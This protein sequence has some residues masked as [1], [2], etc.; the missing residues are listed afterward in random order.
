MKKADRRKCSNLLIA[1]HPRSVLP[2]LAEAIGL[3]EAIFVQQLHWWLIREDSKSVHIIDGRRWVYNSYGEW[4]KSNFQFWSVSTIKRTVYEAERTG[5]VVSDNFNRNPI[6]K[7][8]W[9]TLDYE[10]VEALEN[11]LE[12]GDTST[13]QID[14]M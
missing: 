4:Q 7:T 14:T 12:D 5:L 3:N 2:R 10:A 6:D 1:D 13:C 9:Y 8:K 11:R